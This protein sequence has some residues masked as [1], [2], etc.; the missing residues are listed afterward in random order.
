MRSLPFYIPIFLVRQNIAE[1]FGTYLSID[2]PK[3][4]SCK[5]E[6]VV[7]STTLT[8]LDFCSLSGIQ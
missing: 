7:L 8:T 4:V 5:K 3:K 6:T 2:E 1:L